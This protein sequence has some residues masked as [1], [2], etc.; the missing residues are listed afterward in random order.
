MTRLTNGRIL[1]AAVALLSATATV[2]IAG[3]RQT[4]GAPGPSRAHASRPTTAASPSAAEFARVFV[5]TT[6]RFAEAHGDPKRISE[7]HCVQ[8]AP[9][10]Y[11]CSYVATRPGVPRECRLM[12]ARWT[13]ERASTITITLAGR[14]RR[15][16]SLREALDSLE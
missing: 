6:N 4:R 5:G 12:Q 8:A 16:G 13:P 15:C 9:R 14:T 11:M 1:L 10:Q 3:V 7:P 2:A